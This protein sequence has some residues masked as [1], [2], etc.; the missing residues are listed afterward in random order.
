[1]RRVRVDCSRISDWSS[2]HDVF[3]AA[4][5]FPEFYGRNMNAWIDC[6]SDLADRDSGMST[7]HCDPGSFVVLELVNAKRFKRVCPDQFSAVV[8]C[9]AFVNFRNLEAGEAPALMLAFEA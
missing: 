3:Q 4:F 1:M 7:V 8:E 9:T 5:G 2:F 6:M